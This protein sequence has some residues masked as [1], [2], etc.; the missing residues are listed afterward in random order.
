MKANFLFTGC[1]LAALAVV[2]GAFG[3]HALKPILEGTGKGEVFETAVRYHFY[4]AF[5]LIFVWFLQQK[6]NDKLLIYSGL[7]FIFGIFLFCGSLYVLALT[8]FTKLGIVAP[9]GGLA[10]IAG[11]LICAKVAWKIK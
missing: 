5:G 10:F 9:I 11:W 2:I 1:L 7:L 4:H 8:G 6:N 3:A